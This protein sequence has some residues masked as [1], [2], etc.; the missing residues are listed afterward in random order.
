[1]TPPHGRFLADI[2]VRD[3]SLIINGESI[4]IFHSDKLDQ[5][6]W[7][8]L[9]IDVVLEC[10]GSFSDRHSA[11]KHLESGA[12]RVLFSQPLSLM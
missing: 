7:Q 8:N 3:D 12:K 5:L 9:D 2:D 11:E 6:P 4:A 10:S 1:M